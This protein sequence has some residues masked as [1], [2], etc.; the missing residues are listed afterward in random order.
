MEV[1]EATARCRL[2]TYAVWRAEALVHGGEVAV[3]DGVQMWHTGVPVGYWNGAHVIA[4]PVEP[5]RT[6]R[7]AADW[8]AERKVPYGVLV[9]V[10]LEPAMAAAAGAT[11]LQLAKVQPCMILSAAHYTP[12]AA[13]PAGLAVRRTGPADA[14]DFLAVQ[15]EAFA[16]DPATARDFLAPPIGQPGWTHLTGYLDGVPI[17]SAIGVRTGDAV[18][19]YGVGTIQ[20]ARRRGFGATLTAQLLT[21][22]FSSG[23]VLA[24][25]NPSEMG[26]GVYCRLGFREVPGFAIW[27]PVGTRSAT[28]CGN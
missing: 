1:E 26:A 10:E 21:E 3:I 7:R 14:E 22:A 11:G 23:A 12:P 25:L 18:G 5:E 2:A 9:P 15:V 8:F 4:V 27:L 20:A 16:M 13:L 28:D 24:H 17:A 6:L 19:V